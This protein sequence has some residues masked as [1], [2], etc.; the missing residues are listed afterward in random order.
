MFLFA[1][2]IFRGSKVRVDGYMGGHSAAGGFRS[3]DLAVCTIE[4]ANSLVNRYSKL[5]LVSSS[6]R[7]PLIM[8]HYFFTG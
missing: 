2:E 6:C 1:K 3:L 7:D 4:K 8:H 5:F